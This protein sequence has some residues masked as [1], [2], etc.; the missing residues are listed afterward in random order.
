MGFLRKYNM[1]NNKSCDIDLRPDSTLGIVML[2][3]QEIG[4][5]QRKSK[6]FDRF[7]KDSSL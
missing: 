7:G 1:K 3:P 2:F 4:G 5:K 6:D